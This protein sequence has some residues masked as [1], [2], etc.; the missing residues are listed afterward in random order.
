MLTISGF[1]DYHKIDVAC[2]GPDP[3]TKL[4]TWP[5][6]AGSD[7]TATWDQ[8]P[9]PHEGPIMQYMAACPSSTSRPSRLHVNVADDQ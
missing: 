7:V 3:G 1:A 2:G 6:D 9:Q 4:E 5:V 8:W